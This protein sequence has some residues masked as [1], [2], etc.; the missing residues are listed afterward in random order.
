[1]KTSLKEASAVGLGLLLYQG[2]NLLYGLII[3]PYIVLEFGFL[4]SIFIMFS[5]LIV[6]CSLIIG[7]YNRSKYDWLLVDTI[8]EKISEENSNKFLRITAKI[9]KKGENIF[10]LPILFLSPTL[11]FLYSRKERRAKNNNLEKRTIFLFFASAILCSLGKAGIVYII[12]YIWNL[13]TCIYYL[14]F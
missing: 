12:V 7:I 13:I 3:S 10:I 4:K 2:F 8:K 6:Y 1:M 5:F 11:T 14:I 9:L